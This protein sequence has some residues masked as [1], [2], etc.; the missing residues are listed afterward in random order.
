MHFICA[1]ASCTVLARR[2]FPPLP[3][4]APPSHPRPVCGRA[5]APAV[6]RFFAEVAPLLAV[7]RFCRLKLGLATRELQTMA[8]AELVRRVVQAQSSMR[9]CVVRELTALDIVA[10]VMR[11]ENYLVA[12]IN[13]DVL[14]LTAPVP[15]ERA[16]ARWE[17]DGAE[18]GSGCG[19]SGVGDLGQWHRASRDSVDMV[20][21]LP[22][23]EGPLFRK[24]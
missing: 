16:H 18:G 4:P 12:M 23:G 15:G 9:L 20:F 21:L 10:R 22:S 3:P 7:H 24:G 2:T 8:W 19:C 13:K 11:K 14:R 1:S 5:C 17:T 6:A